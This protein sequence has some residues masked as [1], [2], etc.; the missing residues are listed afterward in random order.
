[1]FYIAAGANVNAK[2]K[3]EN[4]ALMLAAFKGDLPAVKTLVA[5]KADVNAKN[6]DGR[7]PLNLAVSHPAVVEFLRANGA[8]G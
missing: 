5:A 7:T 1:M 3:K 8:D 4:T 2:A 6:S